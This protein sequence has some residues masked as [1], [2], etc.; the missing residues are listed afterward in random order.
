MSRTKINGRMEMFLFNDVI[1]TF[2]FTVIWHRTYYVK[3][4]NKWKL[5]THSTHFIYSY[6]ASDMC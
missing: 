1:N 5:M 6:M 4:Q 2:S 3:D